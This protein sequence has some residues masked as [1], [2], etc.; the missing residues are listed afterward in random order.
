MN[1]KYNKFNI[2]KLS[3]TDDHLSYDG[4]TDFLI[5]TPVINNY[6]IIQQGRNKYI[7]I[8]L[9]N[10]QSH[11]TFLGMFEIMETKF[12][13]NKIVI[14]DIQ[15]NKIIKFKLNNNST[16]FNKNGDIIN[17]PNSNKIIILFKIDQN[18]NI[19]ISQLLEL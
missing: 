19:N 16:I 2:E 14:I 6:S 9:N 18:Y 10:T 12:T 3:N 17:I 13:K 1:I 4:I 7:E 5:Q 15:N 8:I 11:I